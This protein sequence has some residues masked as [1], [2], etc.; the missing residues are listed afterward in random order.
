MDRFIFNNYNEKY[1]IVSVL[2][3]DNALRTGF[4]F[5]SIKRLHFEQ[6][7]SI[8]V[9]SCDWNADGFRTEWP[10]FCVANVKCLVAQG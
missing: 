3:A 1:D 4:Q 2:L 7:V 9:C 6:P 10:E 8:P 5:H